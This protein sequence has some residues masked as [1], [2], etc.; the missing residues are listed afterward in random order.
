MLFFTDASVRIALFLFFLPPFC[1][2]LGYA[3]GNGLISSGKND[4][5]VVII[6]QID[7]VDANTLDEVLDLDGMGWFSF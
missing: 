2:F 4:S 7:G 3:L 1:V 5:G 6:T